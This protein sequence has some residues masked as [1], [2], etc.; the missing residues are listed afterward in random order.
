MS[1][2]FVAVWP[3][4]GAR[5]ALATLARPEEVGVRWVRPEH[6]HV[7]LRFLGEVDE[8][9]AAA[10]L[11]DLAAATP[12]AVLGPAVS[13]LGR[14]VLCVPAAGLDELAAAVAAATAEVGEPP[15]PRP[16][17]GHLT[18]ARLRHRGSCRLAGHKVRAEMAVPE[19]ALVAST[20][21]A[22]GPTYRTV[23]TVPL[24]R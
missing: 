11:D 13:R 24:A 7:T 16:F 19:V 8:D 14:T 3:D 6:W 21:G 5:A 20:L 22:A 12:S 17:A 10:A 4:E 2:L 15:D 23:V 18:L 1:R 9:D